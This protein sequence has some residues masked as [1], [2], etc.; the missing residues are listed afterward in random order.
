LLLGIGELLQGVHGDDFIAANRAHAHFALASG[1]SNCHPDLRLTIGTGN[2]QPL[3]PTS[4]L[5]MSSPSL[6]MAWWLAQ[7][8]RKS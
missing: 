6:R 4:T 1:R 5:A 7:A 2:V 3:S 8:P